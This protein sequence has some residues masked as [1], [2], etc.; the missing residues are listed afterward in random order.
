MAGPLH[1]NEIAIPSDLVRSLI[2]TQFPEYA[3]RPIRPLPPAGTDN[4]LFRLGEDLV[5]RMPRIDWAAESAAFE[6]TWLPQ[7]APY[8]SL[9]IPVPVGLGRPGEGYPWSFTIVPWIEGENPDP[10]R[11]NL[12]PEEWA[13]SLGRFVRSLRDVPP[14]G[15]P[16]KSEGRGA[17]L[18]LLDDWVQEWTAKAVEAFGI[19]RR[20]VLAVWD[21]ALG[22]PGWDGAPRWLHG[23]LHEG[24]LLTRDGRLA[25][26]IDWGAAGRGDPAVELNA[27]W[28]S[29]PPG[30]ERLY[31][32]ATGLDEAA[33]RRARGYRLAPAISGAVYYRD[34]APEMSRGGLA[35]V[36]ALIDS[37]G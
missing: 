1:E 37:L 8:L 11:G 21:D 29:L 10:E 34:T 22:A 28:G 17:P 15:A 9:P 7:I 2:R 32:E 3:D 23:D 27:L 31:L 14:L 4:R 33:W 30:V 13:V 16:V 24:N 6:A 19:D 12:D 35:T 36:R 18:P 26:V 25:A 20:A 5:V